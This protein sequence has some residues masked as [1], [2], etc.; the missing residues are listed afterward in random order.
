MRKILMLIVTIMMMFVVTVVQ[1][2]TWAGGL[3]ELTADPTIKT[4]DCH[5]FPECCAQPASA[6]E[7]APVP[8]TTTSSAPSEG[9]SY[10]NA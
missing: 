7:P 4:C 9:E 6:P 3:P 5:L 1:A 10:H 8:P 2:E